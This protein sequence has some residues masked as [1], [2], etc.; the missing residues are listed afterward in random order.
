MQTRDDGAKKYDE[1][2]AYMETTLAEFMRRVPPPRAVEHRDTFV[3]RF[4]E[5]LPLQAVVQ[6]LART[7]SGL[8]SARLL[9]EYGLFQEQAAIHRV[10]D[11]IHED[12]AFLCLAIIDGKLTNR[13]EQYLSDFF[14]EEFDPVSREISPAK[15]GMIPRDKV[16]AYIA[17]H[18]SSGSDPSRTVRLHTTISKTYSGFVHAASPHIMDMFDGK[19][20]MVRGMNGT[21]RESEYRH[22]LWNYFYRGILSFG[23]A[24]KAFGDGERY[25]SVRKYL[26]DFEVVSGENYST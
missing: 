4:V 16:R 15:R 9:C 11:E 25:Q 8:Y 21:V 10:L 14:S 23:L 18:E 20:F 19:K 6:K 2:L 22:D 7:I 3:Y 24:A 17:N 5:L 1:V 12:I 13:H 26:V